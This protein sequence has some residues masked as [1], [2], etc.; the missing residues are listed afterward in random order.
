M[1]AADQNH[2]Q[3]L[4][5][6]LRDSQAGSLLID[7][8]CTDETE[9]NGPLMLG[10]GEPPISQ[11][12][13]LINLGDAVPLSFSRFDRVYEVIDA[14]EPEAGRARYQFYRD[15]GYPLQTLKITA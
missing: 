10:Q 13:L 4:S 1:L 12:D 14:A 5:A 7:D 9:V 11:H 8:Y 15:R 3:R 2:V 6:Q